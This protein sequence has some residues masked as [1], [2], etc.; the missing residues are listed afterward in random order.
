MK[1]NNAKGHKTKRHKSRLKFPCRQT[2]YKQ[3]LTVL[4]PT[5][6]QVVGQFCILQLGCIYPTGWKKNNIVS[7]SKFK[8]VK[9]PV[10]EIL[11]IG[12]VQTQGSTA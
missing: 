11:A 9:F 8:M 5:L 2:D 4:C 12:C 7:N 6:N 10:G 3:C 1:K